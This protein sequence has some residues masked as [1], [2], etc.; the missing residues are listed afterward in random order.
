MKNYYQ[1]DIKFKIGYFQESSPVPYPR[2]NDFWMVPARCINKTWQLFVGKNNVRIFPQHDL[3]AELKTKL[4]FIYAMG[5]PY[6]RDREL[7]GEIELFTYPP[8]KNVLDIGWRVSE[9][10]FTFLMNDDFLIELRG[11]YDFMRHIKNHDR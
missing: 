1:E 5:L 11:S 8:S 2:D 10:W 6:M 9:T 7:V 4:A 3:H